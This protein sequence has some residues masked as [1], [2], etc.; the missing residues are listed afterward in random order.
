MK[1]KMALSEIILHI[2]SILIVIAGGILSMG[3]TWWPMPDVPAWMTH[4]WQIAL[5]VA[6]LID[7]VGKLVLNYIQSNMLSPMQASAA[8]LATTKVIAP[9]YFNFFL[10]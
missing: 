9:W 1:P 6:T 8:I 2:L 4:S 7:R 5:V 3:D 10:L